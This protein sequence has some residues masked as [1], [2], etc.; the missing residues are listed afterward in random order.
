MREEQRR[1]ELMAAIQREADIQAQVA[2]RREIEAKLAQL[3]ATERW[4]HELLQQAQL[5]SRSFANA[6]HAQRKNFNE[7]PQTSTSQPTTER[8]VLETVTI[9]FFR[10]STRP[11]TTLTSL[12]PNVITS[13]VP[14]PAEAEIIP[15]AAPLPTDSNGVPSAVPLPPDSELLSST[16]SPS[17]DPEIVLPPGV[18]KHC[19]PVQKFI[20]IFKVKN[21][22][23]WLRENCI[24]VKRYYPN[25]SCSQ[26][27]AL[28]SACFENLSTDSPVIA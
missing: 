15:S 3:A 8:V 11:P 5:R 1:L 21:P 9:P 6:N 16:A 25:A 4:H 27:E 2:R 12:E 17:S 18:P 10:P 14:P 13:T 22:Q 20:V 19:A 24:F 26:I 28:L 7:V 23:Q